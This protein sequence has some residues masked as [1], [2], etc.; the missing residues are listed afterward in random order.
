MNLDEAKMVQRAREL[1]QSARYV[2]QQHARLL[3]AES[4]LHELHHELDDA[5]AAK[6]VVAQANVH[7]L[8]AAARRSARHYRRLL[9]GAAHE[10]RLALGLT[11]SIA[12]NE[13]PT[14]PEAGSTGIADTRPN[15]GGTP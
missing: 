14:D 5:A 8:L 7:Q 6:R 4:Q 1:E 3:D 13:L 2:V 10:L 15:G 12:E 9:D 11:A